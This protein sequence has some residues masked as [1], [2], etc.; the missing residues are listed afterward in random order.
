MQRIK[1]RAQF[2]P[3][4]AGSIDT[5]TAHFALHR[6]AHDGVVAPAGP[7][8][9]GPQALFAVREAWIGTVIPRRWARRAVTRNTIR[10][11][12]YSV[13]ASLQPPLSAAAHVVRLRTGYDRTQFTSA[14]SPALKKSVR[15]E[16]QKLF[17]RAAA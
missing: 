15:A 12:I 8:S 5:R 17:E 3:V 13:S 6:V 2:Q 7:G 16:L 11:Q 14:T 10:R 4:K 9:D 1:T